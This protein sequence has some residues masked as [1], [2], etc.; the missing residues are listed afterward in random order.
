MSGTNIC[1]PRPYNHHFASFP[2]SSCSL[3]LSTVAGQASSVALDLVCVLIYRGECET[4]KLTWAHELPTLKCHWPDDWVQ[5]Q[6]TQWHYVTVQSDERLA[7]PNDLL[8]LA[9]TIDF[10][11]E[12]HGSACMPHAGSY[13]VEEGLGPLF[14]Y[15][16]CSYR[17][18]SGTKPAINNMMMTV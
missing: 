16:G 6:L 11:W 9:A 5:L 14:N 10:N 4:M 13:E 12:K 8:H 17:I 2:G 15:W 18:R 7:W 1:Y 3:S